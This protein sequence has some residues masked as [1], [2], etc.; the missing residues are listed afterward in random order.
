MLLALRAWG[1]RAR[2][3]GLGSSDVRKPRVQG[4][5]V[6]G[7]L[8]VWGFRLGL[9]VFGGVGGH[10]LGDLGNWHVEFRRSA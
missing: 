4:F 6:K 5:G 10:E 3:E 8:G 1:F 9:S 7:R 2:A